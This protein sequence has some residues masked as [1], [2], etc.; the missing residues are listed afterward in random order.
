MEL[1]LKKF[2]TKYDSAPFSKI[3]LSDYKEAFEKTIELARAEIDA[4]VKN[5]EK[6]TFQN[7]I[8]ALDYSGERLDRL[9]SLFFNLNSAE[10]SDD[11]Q[12]IAQ[13]VSPL[14]TAFSNDIALN[15]DLFKRVKA[16]YDLKDSLTLT[17]EQAT[18]LEKKFKGFSRNGALLNE[19]DK[20]KLREID[21]E[22]AKVKLTFGEN[23]LA[24][25]NNYQLHITNEADLKSDEK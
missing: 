10:T 11:M 18:L 2:K 4:I 22:L 8:E 23:V 5:T 13:E 17:T 19:E 12:K 6:P 14:L 7:T 20:S 25:T 21:T 24:E 1:F 15:E 9:S 3:N 16:V